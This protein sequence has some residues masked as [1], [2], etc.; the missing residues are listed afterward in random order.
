MFK[1]HALE[2]YFCWFL[3]KI[4]PQINPARLHHGGSNDASPTIPRHKWN[5]PAAQNAAGLG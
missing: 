2:F 4:L 3:N 5:G 1:K